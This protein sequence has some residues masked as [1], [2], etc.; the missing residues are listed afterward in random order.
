MKLKIK[1]LLKGPNAKMPE[2]IEKGDWIDLYSP[3]DQVLHAPSANLFFDKNGELCDKVKVFN[4]HFI[5]P[6]GIAMQL[7]DGFEAHVLPRSS[8][9]KNYGI[10]LV[11]S[12]GMIDQSF[13]G[14]TDEWK[15][16]AITLAQGKNNKIKVGDRIAQ[17]RIELSQKATVWQKLKWLFCSEI[18]LERVYELE[19]ENRG[20]I[21]S[22]GK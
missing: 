22:T 5:L 10:M 3:V 21:G 12:M 9:F 16:W 6:L 8:T 4:Q 17:F 20:G 19:E 2:L 7:P 1:V 11:N 18:E 14:N 15:Y 13:R